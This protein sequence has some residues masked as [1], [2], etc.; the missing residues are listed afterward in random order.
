MQF[1]QRKHHF[2]GGAVGWIAVCCQQTVEGVEILDGKQLPI[3]PINQKLL[4][5][6]CGIELTVQ[7]HSE[8]RFSTLT[9]HMTRMPESQA[10]LRQCASKIGTAYL[11]AARIRLSRT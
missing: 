1:L 11:S 6:N 5:V 2:D 8:Q 9:H 7:N 10:T 3:I 4:G